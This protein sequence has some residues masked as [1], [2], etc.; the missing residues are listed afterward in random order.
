MM[1][2][3]TWLKIY[4]SLGR[5]TKRQDLV[6]FSADN[7]QPQRL[8]FLFPLNPAIFYESLH[9]VKRL[10]I[11]PPQN[12][13]HFAVALNLKDIM[14]ATDHLTFYYP[15]MKDD[16]PKIDL[17]VLVARFGNE[18]YDAVINLDVEPSIQMA[19]L[20]S[21]IETPKRIGFSGPGADELYNIQ[22]APVSQRYLSGAY[23]QILG[24]CDLGKPLAKLQGAE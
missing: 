24:F 8:L 3:S 16:T 13:I 5:L 1:K 18:K 4:R 10:A 14:H 22:I 11:Y 19:K 7:P 2:T 20:I 21:K 23:D 17:D 15:F 6:Q 12:N 9:I